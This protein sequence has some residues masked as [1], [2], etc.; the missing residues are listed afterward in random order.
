MDYSLLRAQGGR[1]SC[2]QRTFHGYLQRDLNYTP[3]KS[4]TGS[5]TASATLHTLLLTRIRL[6]TAAGGSAPQDE[7]TGRTWIYTGDSISKSKGPSTTRDDYI[8]NQFS[9]K[10]SCE[11][12]V[13]RFSLTPMLQKSWW[14]GSQPRWRSFKIGDELL[15]RLWQLVKCWT[16]LE[17]CNY[18]TTKSKLG[19]E[20]KRTWI[21]DSDR[22]RPMKSKNLSRMLL[23]QP[24]WTAKPTWNRL[25]W[26][27]LDFSFAS[28]SWVVR[29][30]C[31]FPSFIYLPCQLPFSI[32]PSLTGAK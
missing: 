7:A 1:R 24:R 23:P 29:D 17:I 30:E 18:D 6:T 32:V 10:C 31:I 15:V 21:S 16:L 13:P 5:S 2:K 4:Y 9:R 22:W 8:T 27:R 28:D 12:P 25:I 20:E 11:K 26:L 3:S 14:S 19:C